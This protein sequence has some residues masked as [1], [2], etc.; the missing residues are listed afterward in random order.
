MQDRDV[1]CKT[2]GC[3]GTWSWTKEQQLAAGVRLLKPLP[4]GP[5]PGVATAEPQ[6]EKIGEQ[7]EGAPGVSVAQ[8]APSGDEKRGKKQ[9]RQKR[10]R[11]PK[12]PEKMCPNCLEF[13]AGKKTMEI[14]CS[15]CA[16][17]IYWPPESQLQT[18]LGNWAVPGMCGACKRD[19]TEAARNLARE[20]LRHPVLAPSPAG[21]STSGESTNNESSST[22]SADPA[23]ST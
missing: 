5:A 19:A 4:V 14:P 23:P 10:H 6:I 18:H 21:E 1:P 15:Q 16:T 7:L 9:R 3:T 12:P 2:D 8:A 17:P 11:E 22:V 13:L 20:A